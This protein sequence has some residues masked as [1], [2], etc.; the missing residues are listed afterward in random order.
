MG[1]VLVAAYGFS[2]LTSATLAG[3]RYRSARVGILVAPTLVATHAAYVAGFASGLART[4][5]P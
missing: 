3:L 5:R 2:V 1:S 4:P